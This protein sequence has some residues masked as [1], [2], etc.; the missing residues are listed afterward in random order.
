MSTFLQDA[1][2]V[3]EYN[4]MSMLHELMHGTKYVLPEP[5][6]DGEKAE[7]EK[8]PQATLTGWTNVLVYMPFSVQSKFG[9]QG[10][11]AF[12]H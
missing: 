2:D 6:K 8:P 3:S 5:E 7:K 4:V 10:Y 12:V 11:H 9:S 1:Q